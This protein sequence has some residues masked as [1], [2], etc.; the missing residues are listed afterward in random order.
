MTENAV[1]A[2]K[3]FTFLAYL[4]LLHLYA[5]FHLILTNNSLII[6]HINI[7]IDNQ[8]VLILLMSIFADFNV[9]FT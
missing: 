6:A 8:S 5:N 2:T 9:F 3:F 1:M 4:K 7:H